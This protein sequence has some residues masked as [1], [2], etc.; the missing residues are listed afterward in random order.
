VHLRQ[1][2]DHL[3]A[4]AVGLTGDEGVEPVCGG[5]RLGVSV[6]A[7]GEGGDVPHSA[8]SGAVLGVQAWWARVKFPMPRWTILTGAA[9]RPKPSRERRGL[10]GLGTLSSD[11]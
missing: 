9:G 4:V 5:E 6:T 11:W 3:E 10:I 2:G 1:R 8:A 7:P